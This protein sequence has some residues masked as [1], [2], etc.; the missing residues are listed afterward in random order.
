VLPHFSESRFK[1]SREPEQR[2]KRNALR[3]IRW[4]HFLLVAFWPSL[5]VK[6]MKEHVAQMPR[7]TDFA[8][9]QKESDTRF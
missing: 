6:S 2:I 3:A 7:G 1:D 8:R 9:P 5:G 4:I